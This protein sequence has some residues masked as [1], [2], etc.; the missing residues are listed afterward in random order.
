[1]KKFSSTR[2]AAVG[3]AGALALAG[4]VGT[5][6]VSPANA[7]SV[8][9]TYS[10]VLTGLGPTDMPVTATM[11]LPSSIQSGA[12]LPSRSVSMSVD[13][14]PATVASLAQVLGSLFGHQ[15]TGISGTADGVAFPVAGSASP[16]ALNTVSIP[17]AHPDSTTGHLILAG[18]GTTK[19]F[20]AGLPGAH[21]V[22]MPSTFTFVPTASFVGI[23]DQAL[24]PINC[25]STE[26]TP[27]TVATMNVVKATSVTTAKLLNAPVT[28][29]K[30]AKILATVKAAGHAAT[31]KVYAYQGTKLL[32]SATLS[33]GKATL[34]LP[35]LA[36][37]S[38]TVKVLYKATTANQASSKSLTFSVTRG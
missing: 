12:D 22:T 33:G 21:A 25:T 11:A 1:M 17:V 15:L 8:T 3:M 5:G 6:V 13:I 19:A 36:R 7:S 31:G 10:C 9:D 4:V 30:H 38:H 18:T 29:V 16:L 37:G 35:L 23:P 20:R 28:T 26:S 24:T 32:K 27:S 14:L 2:A 34:V